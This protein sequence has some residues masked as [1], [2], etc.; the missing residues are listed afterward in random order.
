MI[1]FLNENAGLCVFLFLNYD[2]RLVRLLIKI[3]D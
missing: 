3:N 2:N 1:T